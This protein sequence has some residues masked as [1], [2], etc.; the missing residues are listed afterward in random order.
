MDGSELES[1]VPEAREEALRKQFEK[2]FEVF[3]DSFSG[4][5]GGFLASLVLYPIE[6]YRTRLQTL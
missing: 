3:I 4:A 1:I 6:N 5:S 2:V